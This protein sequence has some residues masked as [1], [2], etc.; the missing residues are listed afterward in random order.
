MS[1]NLLIKANNRM[2]VEYQMNMWA[3]VYVRCQCLN[4]T[5]KRQRLARVES[6]KQTAMWISDEEWMFAELS[7][8]LGCFIIHES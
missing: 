8:Q 7:D 1:L 2:K 3:T 6:Q 4:A 5:L